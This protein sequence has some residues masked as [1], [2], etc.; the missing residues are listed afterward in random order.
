MNREQKA[1]VID[2]IAAEITAS[3]AIFA[4]DYRGI[5]VA[6]ADQLRSS[7][8]Q[9]DAVFRVVKNSLTERAAQQAGAEPL[10]ELLAGPT[11]LTF[12]RGDAAAAAKAV[13]DFTRTT[14]LLAFKG[15][16][17]DGAALSASDVGAIS[18]LP[19][20][21]VLY[22]QLV[23]LVA[24]PLAGLARTLN[25]L[26]GGLAVGLGGV[27]AQKESDP[28]FAGA[29]SAA[30]AD[31]AGAPEASPAATGAEDVDASA[32]AVDSAG[33]ESPERPAAD[34]GGATDAS[35]AAA[36]AEDAGDLADSA[37]AGTDAAA[38]AAVEEP[39]AEEPAAEEPAADGAAS[40]EPAAAE[41]ARAEAAVDGAASAETP[42]EEPAAEQTLAEEVAAEDPVVEDE[43][44]KDS[45]DALET[46]TTETEAAADP[47]AAT[48]AETE[49]AAPEAPSGDDDKEDQ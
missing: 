19:S 43:P 37:L 48:E 45:G 36:G 35:P 18:R 33:A 47:A 14:Q 24:S 49:G 6:Q 1:A 15:G 39:A 8:R 3:Q 25:A 44:E 16:V 9:A 28:A 41:P 29:L 11:A 7:L 26:I 40:A 30:V 21:D 17:M 10:L 46:T 2:E 5:S 42:A 4:V 32:E 22:G 31:D 23:G 38:E 13:A 12:V 34:D 27:L 20:R